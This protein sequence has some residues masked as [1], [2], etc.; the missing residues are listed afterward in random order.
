MSTGYDRRRSRSSQLHA[1]LRVLRLMRRSALALF[2]LALLAFTGTAAADTVQ[3]PVGPAPIRYRDV[4]FPK[5]TVT[6]APTYAPAPDPTRNPVTLTLDMYRP[7]C[8]PQPG[9]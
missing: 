8:D 7:T 5:L 9:R 3:A 2:A 4:I 1:P 6:P